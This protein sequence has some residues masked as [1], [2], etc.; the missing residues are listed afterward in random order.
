MDGNVSLRNHP[1]IKPPA[2]AYVTSGTVNSDNCNC[3]GAASLCGWTTRG[4]PRRLFYGD[5]ATGFRRQGGQVR[6]YKSTLK[7]LQIN[8]TNWE[9]LA[10]GRPTQKK[11]V[12]TGTAIYE[13]NRITVAKP[14]CE[15]RKSQ[16]RP[17][18]NASTR[19]SPTCPRCQRTL[20]A[21]I[22]LIGRLCTN[23]RSAPAAV[24]ASTSASTSTL[25]INTDRTPELPTPLFFASTSA[26]AAPVSTTTAFSPDTPT[27]INLPTVNTSVVD[28]A[29]ICPHCDRTFTSHIGLIGHSQIYRT[30]TG[31]PEP[32]APTYTH[33]IRLIY[34]T[35]PAQ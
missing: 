34:L 23:F 10:Q 1:S 3:A 16:L 5:V 4:Y 19:P 11:A 14:R 22:A 30:E 25:T 24:P 26:V 35:V 6:C 17:P 21:P 28:S 15:A 18:R 27:N 29:H 2:V 32:G 13:A 8:P 7:R 33:F 12:K 20:R 9:D 31:K